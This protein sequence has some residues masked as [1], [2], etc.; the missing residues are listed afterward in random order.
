ME[1][2]AEKMAEYDVKRSEELEQEIQLTKEEMQDAVKGASSIFEYQD[3]INEA[4]RKKREAHK[5]KK[6]IVVP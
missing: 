1:S 5:A 2:P 4:L 6:D 3:R